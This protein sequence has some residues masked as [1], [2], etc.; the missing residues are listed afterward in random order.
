MVVSPEDGAGSG[1]GT[2]ADAPE[3]RSAEAPETAPETA[4]EAAPEQKLPPEFRRV[5]LLTIVRGLLL[6]VLGLLLLIDPVRTDLD[7]LELVVG[8]FLVVDGLV[9]ALGGVW[10]RHQPGW[11]AWLAQTVVDVVLGLVVMFWPD[12]TAKGLYYVLAAW[13]IALGI[14]IVVTSG[15]LARARD[16]EW[17]WLLT[18]GIVAFL[19]GILMVVRPVD[20]RDIQ[21]TAALLFAFLAWAIG[22]IFVVTGFATRSVALELR[23]L[24]AQLAAATAAGAGGPAG[25]AGKRPRSVLGGLAGVPATPDTTTTQPAVLQGEQEPENA[26]PEPAGAAAPL[27]EIPRTDDDV[28]SAPDETTP[29][30]DLGSRP[31][32]DGITRP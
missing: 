5:W 28:P 12:L 1:P 16:L 31:G 24:R 13:A 19:F 11:Q 7:R 21:A 25:A 9:A 15:V 30:D 8:A 10:H 27:P 23:E 20:T 26:E 3:P 2:A 4:A 22:A 14:T 18:V 29:R 17:T 32:D 6:L